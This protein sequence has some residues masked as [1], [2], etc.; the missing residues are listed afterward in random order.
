VGWHRALQ[1]AKYFDTWVICEEHEFADEIR[2]YTAAHGDIPGLRF[3]FVP[4]DQRE[5]SWGQVHDAIWYAVLR[6]W[7]RRAFQAARRL[8]ER[9]GFD[10]VHQVTFCGYREPGFLWRLGT[11]FLWGPVGGTQDYPW[12]FLAAAGFGGALHELSRTLVN[13]LQLRLSPSVRGASRRAAAI[14]AANSTVERDFAAAFGVT[15]Q[16]LLETGLAEVHGAPRTRHS[17]GQ[18]MRILW[19]GL[20]I[21]RK[22]LHLLL[23]ALAGL[24]RDVPYELRILGE[25][26]L[27]G[28]WQRLA[29]RLGVAPH[30]T[31]LG[32]L[33]HHEALRQYDWADLFAFTSLRDTSG[34]VVLEALASGVPVVCLDHQGMHDIVTD[35]CG[36][37]I[38]VTTPG[39]VISRLTQSIVQL[40]REPAE[41]ERM[42]RGAI[43]RAEEHLWSRQEQTMA[44]LYRSI[45]N[46]SAAGG[47]ESHDS[48]TF[49]GLLA[50]GYCDIGLPR[51]NK[52]TLPCFPGSQDNTHH[53]GGNRAAST[54]HQPTDNPFG[55][56]MY[57]RVASLVDG[58][59]APTWNVT[60]ERFR[61]QLAGLLSRGWRPWSLRRVVACR[62]AGEPVPAR[63]F[64]VTFDDGYDNVYHNAW[65]ILKELSVPATVFL[66][67][68]YLDGDRP[69]AFDNWPAAGFGRVPATAWRPLSTAHCAEMIA[70]GLI[71]VGSHTHTHADLRS[72]PEM[73][74]RDLARSLELLRSRFGLADAAFAFPFGHAGPELAAVVRE[75]GATCGLTA[76]PEAVARGADPFTW[77]RFAVGRH[78]TAATLLL[79]LGGWYS[80]LRGVWRWLRR[81]WVS[82]SASGSH[83]SRGNPDLPTLCVGPGDAERRG[84]CVPTRSV[85]TRNASLMAGKV[86]SR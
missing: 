23:R 29:R 42:S 25:G 61:R 66:T 56:L 64:V 44:D 20:L 59:P 79:K 52:R 75:S 13:R 82:I 31:W 70:G 58:V 18:A 83:A 24:P 86:T 4:I 41:W 7:H 77:G 33:P 45:L 9:L 55:I 32:R 71:E 63:T 85:G 6:R 74:R 3:V 34:N 72:R 48:R 69:F 60:P 80:S 43:E 57:H 27:R 53:R 38:A 50:P 84:Q 16:L 30:V 51:R 62:R 39:E 15:P 11:P 49:R 67:T 46:R 78:D 5:W 8:H 21:H 65:P 81:P 17:R 73:F 36:V 37:K 10:L 35:R 22:A 76:E 12:R 40:W 68:A 14:L 26:S 1:S 19:S 54:M 47:G 28:R 2:R